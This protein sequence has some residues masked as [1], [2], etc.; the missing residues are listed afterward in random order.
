[1]T[2]KKFYWLK[3]K[4]D[5]FRQKAIKKLRKIAGGDTYTIIYLKMLLLAIK[6]EN[7]LYFDGL[8]ETFA[9]ELALELDEEENNIR[10][11]LSFLEHQNLIE[12]VDTD[13][14]L[15][16]ECGLMVGKESESA[17]RMRRHH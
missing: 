6:T 3:L 15:L 7:K 5:F 9:E 2:N 16:I 17:E 13:E 12:L 8:E 1:M 11:T 10:M 14:Y 4:D